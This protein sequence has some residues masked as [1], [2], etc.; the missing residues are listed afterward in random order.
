MGV[1]Y[2]DLYRVYNGIYTQSEPPQEE[3]PQPPPQPVQAAPKK[4]KRRRKTIVLQ[5]MIDDPM[6]D[7][8]KT[9]AGA[10]LGYSIAKYLGLYGDESS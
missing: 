3:E 5:T 9:V 10:A 8:L 7:L 1:N 4:K 6:R 2:D